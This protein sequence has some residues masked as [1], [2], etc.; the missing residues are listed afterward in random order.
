MPRIK[1]YANANER[2]KAF[3]L[4]KKGMEFDLIEGI[5]SI[6][7]NVSKEKRN[8]TDRQTG[9]PNEDMDWEK[10]EKYYDSTPMRTFQ[11]PTK[12]IFTDVIQS[13][14]ASQSFVGIKLK[15]KLKGAKNNREYIERILHDF[16]L[17]L[18][19]N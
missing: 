13:I 19:E 1:K 3:R 4:K 15:N 8:E 14:H 2:L 9:V 11:K 16:Y 12:K 10:L 6:N 18:Q 5:V 17:F 7:G